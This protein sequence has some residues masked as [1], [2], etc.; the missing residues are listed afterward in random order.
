MNSSIPGGAQA[1]VGHHPDAELVHGGPQLPL[2]EVGRALHLVD[3][4]GDPG[5]LVQPL[6]L[7]AVEVGH[8]DALQLS[9]VDQ[10]LHL[11]P[12]ADV[13]HLLF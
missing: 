6:D 8:P 5:R 3:G 9:L 7:L 2:L 11:P 10:P 4:D 12:D 13:I 1:G